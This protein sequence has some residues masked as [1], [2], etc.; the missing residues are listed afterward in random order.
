MRKKTVVVTCLALLLTAGLASLAVSGKE[1]GDEKSQRRIPF[2]RVWLLDQGEDMKGWLR[3]CCAAYEKVSGV[4]VYLRRASDQELESARGGKEDVPLPDLT[5]GGEGV[6]LARRGYALIL[7]DETAPNV[8]PETGGGLFFRPSPT[9]GP[10]E[11]PAPMPENVL[12]GA[13]LVPPGL[14]GAV[15]QEIISDQPAAALAQGKAKAALLTAGEAEAL[16]FGFRAFAVPGGKGSL[17][18]RGE[19]LSAAG[20]ALLDYLLSDAAQQRLSAQGLYSPRLLLY[21]GDGVRG[22]I[23]KS[24]LSID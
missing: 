4:R 23:E 3:A 1:D 9:W 7:K 10:P 11:T 13:V 20:E 21:G 15:P 14:S 24:L 16:P 18:V 2:A 22:I 12:Q 17:P 5:V 6:C 19:A 8:S